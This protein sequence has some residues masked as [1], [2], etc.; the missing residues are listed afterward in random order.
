MGIRRENRLYYLVDNTSTVYKSANNIIYVC[1]CVWFVSRIYGYGL[2]RARKLISSVYSYNVNAATYVVFYFLGFSYDSRDKS[3]EE[4]SHW[5]DDKTV[6]G[7]VSF[8]LGSGKY[9]AR[10][11]L[12][13]VRD[14]DG[15]LY[16]CRVDF[17]KS[18][19]RNHNVNLTVICK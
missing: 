17:K 15:G 14:S 8:E 5:S 6:G 18:P 3:S 16:R 11:T 13:A 9:P 4:A 1:V 19:T 10:L 7:R 12:Q 2:L